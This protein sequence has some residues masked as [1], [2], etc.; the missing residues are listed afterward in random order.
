MPWP[1]RS[2]QPAPGSLLD[3]TT[4]AHSTS[5]VSDQLGLPDTSP[6]PDPQADL[7]RLYIRVRDACFADSLTPAALASLAKLVVLLAPFASRTAPASPAQLIDLME[8]A[9]Q[10][11]PDSSAFD[12]FSVARRA[13]AFHSASDRDIYDAAEAI[14]REAQF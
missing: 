9:L 7:A 14:D 5:L 6:A 10:R 4:R 11:K 1:A 8:V 13:I 3:L 2:H 12:A